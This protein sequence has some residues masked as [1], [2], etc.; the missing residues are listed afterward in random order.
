MGDWSIVY[1]Q[2]PLGVAVHGI[3][4]VRD[5][6][7]K[8]VYSMEGLAVGADGRQKPIGTQETDRIRFFFENGTSANADYS[9]FA[10]QEVEAGSQ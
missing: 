1:V 6:T 8:V 3:I 4:E 7:G 5:D 10:P 9:T 2:K